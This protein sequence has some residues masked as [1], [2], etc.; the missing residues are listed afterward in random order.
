MR[1]VEVG[2]V[3]LG[4]MGAGIAAC[5]VRVGVSVA[6]W[7]TNE[8]ALGP[9]RGRDGVHVMSPGDMA[10]AGTTMFFVVPATAEIEACLEADDGVLGRATTG[11]VVYDM[12]TSYPGD[13]RRLAQRAAEHGI[14]YLDAAMSG[15]ATGAAAGTLTLMIGGDRDVFVRT[16]EQLMVIADDLF[17]LGPVGAGQTMKLIHN[18]ACHSIFMATCEAGRMA[19]RA[20]IGLGDMIDVFNVSNAQSFASRE[21]FPRH[22]LSGAW[23]GRSRVYNL[24]KDLSMA[25]ALAGELGTKVAH[26]RA[27]LDA[28]E[29][30]VARGMAE[31]DF[32]LLYRDFDDLHAGPADST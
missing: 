6:V 1:D 26:G 19:E 8:T 7:D 16:R 11:L 29:A 23:D 15:G 21:R 17:H 13:T 20:G 24:H 5:F 32:T 10:E 18:M 22:I 31:S 25:V 30:A 3:G 27:T 4:N 2:V 14:S 12:T 9:F 28:L